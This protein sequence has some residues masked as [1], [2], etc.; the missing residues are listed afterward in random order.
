[1]VLNS[2]ILY[3]ENLTYGKRPLSRQHYT[4]SIIEELGSVWLQEKQN[5]DM[6]PGSSDTLLKKLIK[7]PNKKEKECCVCSVRGKKGREQRKRSRTVCGK[8]K[9]RP[10]W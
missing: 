9:K 6:Q 3:K 2:C 7:L 4:I 10:L 8:Y 5:R 1:M